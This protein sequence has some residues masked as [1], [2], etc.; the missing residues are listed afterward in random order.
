MYPRT[1]LEKGLY[2]K[3]V[4][5]ENEALVEFLK[6]TQDNPQLVRGFYEQALIFRERGYLKL[7]E[8]ALEQALA[9]QPDYNE[10]RVLLATVRIQQGNVGGAVQ[11]LSRTLGLKI[12]DSQE[13]NKG[14]GSTAPIVLQTIHTPIKQAINPT[15]SPTNPARPKNRS[16]TITPAEPVL[17]ERTAACE[18]ASATNGNSKTETDNPHATDTGKHYD[19]GNLKDSI[20]GA[21]RTSFSNSLHL[22][23]LGQGKDAG[24][25]DSPEAKTQTEVASG[26]SEDTNST[27]QKKKRRKS[28]REGDVTGDTIASTEKTEKH[29]KRRFHL[30]RSKKDENTTADRGPQEAVPKIADLV[31]LPDPLEKAQSEDKGDQANTTTK[32]R[33]NRSVK[34]SA[35][36]SDTPPATTAPE[37]AARE[38]TASPPV[39]P[40]LENKLAFQVPNL[41]A[42]HGLLNTFPIAGTQSAQAAA[43]PKAK[44]AVHLD[45]DNWARE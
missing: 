13:T 33:T 15:T 24:S 18:R 16:L 5:R 39:A 30:R 37:D 9:A 28:R 8:S 4:Q 44:P 34:R 1:H 20:E 12:E 41:E 6:A 35:D 38:E 27:R 21:L 19:L 32:K 45:T 11:E 10:A 2:Y 36:K 31:Q 3:Q 42:E 26:E 23:N 25:K 17:K 22:F 7:A 40:A 29:K 14:K 43:V